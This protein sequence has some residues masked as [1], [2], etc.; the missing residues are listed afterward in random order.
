MSLEVICAVDRRT[1]PDTALE[2]ERPRLAAVRRLGDGSRQ[3]RHRHVPGGADHVVVPD[4]GSPEKVRVDRDAVREV[5]AGRVEAVGPAERGLPADAVGTALGALSL[6]SRGRR[7]HEPG[8]ERDDTKGGR[9]HHGDPS[10]H[11][12]ALALLPPP[13]GG[14]SVDHHSAIGT[15]RCRSSW[16][17][18]PV[19]PHVE[20]IS[21]A[22]A[23]QIEGRV[24]TTRKAPGNTISHHATS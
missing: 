6:G 14:N 16:Q 23:E 3:I 5:L 21:Q 18:S 9:D 22:V 20:R 11:W 8:G 13:S 10:S 2:S 19:G 12:I 7:G 1:E 24:V 17:P 4:Q 15:S